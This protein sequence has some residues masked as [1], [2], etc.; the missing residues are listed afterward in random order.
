MTFA[1][2]RPVLRRAPSAKCAVR[3]AGCLTWLGLL[4]LALSPLAAQEG[5]IFE[6]EPFDVITLNESNQNRVLQTLPLN[7]PG[8]K[9]PTN[10][11]P[12]ST[13]RVRL[14]SNPDEEL[15]VAWR[16]IAKIELFE[17]RVLQRAQELIQAHKFDEAFEHLTFLRDNYPQ[18]TGLSDTLDQLLFTEAA[19]LYRERQFERALLLLDEIYQRKADQRVVNALTR[20]LEA[21]LTE[22]FAAADYPDVRRVYGVAQQR[23]GEAL[24]QFLGEWQQR[25][26]ATA[27]AK[28]AEARSQLNEGRAREA[29]LTARQAQEIWPKGE[30]VESLLRETA[31]RYPLLTVGVT[32]PYA[33]QDGR[34]MFNW[35]ARRVDRLLTRHLFELDGIGADGGQYQCV[36][37]TAEVT[38]NGRT[39]TL[40]LN[41][42]SNS[43]AVFSGVDV[44]RQLL[45]LADPNRAVFD[46]AWAVLL[47]GVRVDDIHRIDLTFRRPHLR[48]QA[49]LDIPLSGGETD[50][51]SAYWQPYRGQ[52]AQ[53]DD[54]RYLANEH[55]LLAGSAQPHEIVEHTFDNPQQAVRALR[56]GEIDLL[57]R[58]FPA[59]VASLRSDEQLQVRAYRLPSLHVLVPNPTRPYTANRVFRRCVAYALDRD[60][61]L[62]QE[63]LGGRDLSGCR[64]ISG[65]FPPGIDG[66]DPLG[67]AYDSRVEPRAYDPRHARTLLQLARIE[68][69]AEAQKN[70]QSPPE[71]TELVLAFPASELARVACAAIVEDLKVLG[72]P[73]SLRPL[74]PGTCRPDDDRWDFLYV[75]Y[76]MQEPLVDAPRLLA[77]DGFAGCPSPHL[78]LALRQLQRATSWNQAGDRLRAVHQICYDDTSVIP[79][80]QLID[81]LACRKE[82]GGVV[83]NPV[84]TYQ[85]IEG[86]SLQFAE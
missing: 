57:D 72:L 66:D 58:V 34:P 64:L 12:N 24:A 26:E 50:G 39:L 79:L 70:Q 46:P 80:W 51:E 22:R 13:L 7:L 9:L 19:V 83:E 42:A 4:L 38:P 74:A 36:M 76:V 2:L 52:F 16:G 71:M 82:L 73:S 31:R 3:C 67:Y 35:A 11:N 23:Y 48:V 53:D 41:A 28:V 15:E 60:H 6:Q 85:A 27:Q 43:A 20:V 32:Q 63:L 8:R 21:L 81:Y 61:I 47:E 86:W 65:P 69:N 40:Q 77:A 44:S 78:N 68:I 10:P 33:P 37:G 55:Y 30:G 45:A 17:Q 18:V 54:P 75:D 84:R 59:D 56:R 29:F 14:L 5:K 1:R 49:L 25:F 62:R